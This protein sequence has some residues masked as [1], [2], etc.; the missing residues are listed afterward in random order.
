[1]LALFLKFY[2][3]DRQRIIPPTSQFEIGRILR[4]YEKSSAT[5]AT[6]I[7]RSAYLNSFQSFFQPSLTLAK[8]E[9]YKL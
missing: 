8:N 2:H 7:S 3:D 6:V 5:K 4:D 9:R 1:M